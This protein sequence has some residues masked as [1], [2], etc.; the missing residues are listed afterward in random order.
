MRIFIS[1]SGER[2]KA[3]AEVLR[4][5]LPGVIQAVQPYYSPDD[6][7]K[8]AR[9][10]EEIAKVL[11]E[12]RVGIICLTRENLDA[13]WIVFEAGALSKK[14]EKS[15]VSPI[16]FGVEPTDLTGPLIQFA[17]SQVREDGRQTPDPHDQRRTRRTQAKR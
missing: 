10:S 8:G 4:Q 5:W 7:T 1:W 13:P 2:S 16:L 11:E 12:S 15:K 17:S 9:W 6:I 14:L 3:L